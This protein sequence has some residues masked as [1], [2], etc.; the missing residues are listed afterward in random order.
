MIY[1]PCDLLEYHITDCSSPQSRITLIFG[2]VMYV[3]DIIR[4]SLLTIVQI[5]LLS[6]RARVRQH[7]HYDPALGLD[8][9]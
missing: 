2:Y 3:A 9:E 1:G 6:H 7:R 4:C 5:L 8:V